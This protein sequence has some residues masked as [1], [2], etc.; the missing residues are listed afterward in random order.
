MFN[1][2][3]YRIGQFIAL[4]LPLKID[5]A[6]TRKNIKIE[7]ISYIDEVLARGKGAI[8]VTAHLGNWELGGVVIALSGYPFWAVALPHKYKKIDNFF[9]HQRGSKGM[10]VI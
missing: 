6:Y 7:N 2:I 1:Y 5:L 4:Y 3:I 10:K 9:N 8:T